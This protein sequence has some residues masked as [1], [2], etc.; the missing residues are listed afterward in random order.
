MNNAVSNY[1]FGLAYKDG[2]CGPVGSAS[3]SGKKDTQFLSQNWQKDVYNPLRCI[4]EKPK[5][6][7]EMPGKAH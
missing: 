5:I 4:Y 6:Y 7:G 2:G 1:N 3:T